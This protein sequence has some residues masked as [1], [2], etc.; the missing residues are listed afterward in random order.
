[1]EADG[2]Q[3]TIRHPRI[4]ETRIDLLNHPTLIFVQS[5]YSLH[6]LRQASRRSWRIGQQ[7]AVRVFYLHYEDMQS[8]C[9]RLMGKELLVSLAMEAKF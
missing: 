5:G 9:L 3:V 8:S 7:R 6:T 2:V 4:I 1:M